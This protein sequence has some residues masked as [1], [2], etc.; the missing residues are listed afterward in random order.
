MS[1]K[2]DYDAIIIGAGIGGLVCG[3]YLAKEGM[4][5]LIVEKNPDPGGYC[6]S[7][8]RN[9]F[10]FDA[11]A[12]S[13]GSLRKEGN[14]RKI[15]EELE[16]YYQIKVTRSNPQDIIITPDFKISF[17]NGLSKTINE[18]QDKFKN[19]KN[20]LERFF[21]YVNECNGVAFNSLRRIT[22]QQLLDKYF[23]DYKLKAIL[24]F[25]IF[26]NA[27][28]PPSGISAFAAVTLYKEF[29]LDGGYYPE[30]GMGVL[31]DR[32]LERFKSL[33]GDVLMPS[34][35]TQI[36]V[37]NNCVESVEIN[38]SNYIS[39]RYIISN[40]DATE[41]FL[42]LIGKRNLS[43]DFSECIGSLK[44]SLSA[45][46]LYLG[47]QGN[48]NDSLGDSNVW[49]LPDYDVEKLYRIADSGNI[50]SINW[51]L[52]RLLPD[53][54]S[55]LMLINS[56]FKDSQYWRDNKQRLIDYFIKRIELIVPDILSHVT[57]KD[58]AT[59]ETLYKWTL[60][61]HG[62]AYG[63]ESTLTQF[64]IPGLSQ[65]TPINNLF[66][67]GHWATLTQGVPG[68]AYLGR[69]TAKMILIKESK[70]K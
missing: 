4:R 50:D 62:A 54:K 20:N 44:S 29:M 24:A 37:K 38:R 42:D 26:G 39:T 51:F 53:K 45:F 63:W 43:K 16:I 49:F 23:K 17:W 28:L 36:K 19:E 25:P 13:L 67:V 8:T 55:L 48:I 52:L 47:I 1:K 33:G 27:G 2:Y 56:P 46:V 65:A 61:R 9:G 21:T 11:C 22:F 15:L 6:T 59:P 30:G 57:L 18:F 3:C 35:V 31:P 12:H 14:I 40:V 10:R 41:T 69:N 34:F 64:A 58:A 7:F 5:V 68:V 66:L 32:L 70:K 60:N